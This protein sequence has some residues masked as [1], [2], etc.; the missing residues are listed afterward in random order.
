MDMHAA[1]ENV[2]GVLEMTEEPENSHIEIQAFSSEKVVE[3]TVQ[4][5]YICTNGCS[6]GHRQQ[7]G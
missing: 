2:R 7:I 1:G 5:K 3:S 4:M 6:T